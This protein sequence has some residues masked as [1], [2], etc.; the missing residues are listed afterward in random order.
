MLEGITL[1]SISYYQKSVFKGSYRGMNFHLQKAGDEEN[2]ALEAVAWKGPFILEKTE[3]EIFTK[4]FEFSDAG[5]EAASE[6]LS[7]QQKIL[8]GNYDKD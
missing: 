7:D 5:I 6:W 4:R 1:Y 2:P 8:G 3:E